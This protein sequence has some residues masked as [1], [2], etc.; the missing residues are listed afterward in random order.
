ME[1]VNY[2]VSYANLWKLLID[3]KIKKTE[4]KAKAKISPGTYTK[5]NQ[6]QFVS[7]NVIARICHVLD[8]RV[9]DVLEINPKDET[10]AFHQEIRPRYRNFSE[11]Q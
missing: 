8:C 9:K 1:G 6:D 3:R 7:M 11:L 4:L 5:L 10:E 2:T